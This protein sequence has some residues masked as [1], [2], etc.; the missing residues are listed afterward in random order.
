MVATYTLIS[1]YASCPSLY[2]WNGTGYSYV[3]DVSNAGWSGYIGYMTNTGSIVNVGG[4]PWDNVKL[5]PDLMATMKIDGSNCY[6][7]ALFQQADE[8]F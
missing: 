6:Q 2:T 3:T 4:N 5:N 1:G 7:L 8:I